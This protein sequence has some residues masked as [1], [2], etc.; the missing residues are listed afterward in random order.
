MLTGDGHRDDRSLR[1]HPLPDPDRG[2]RV[3]PARGGPG[4]LARR[5]D[6]PHLG[7]AHAEQPDQA[8]GDG[9]QQREGQGQLRGDGAAVG[10]SHPMPSNPST[11]SKSVLSNCLPNPPDSIV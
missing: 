5:V 6:D 2:A 10:A 3:V 11:W 4:R 1:G 9:E 7:H 8:G